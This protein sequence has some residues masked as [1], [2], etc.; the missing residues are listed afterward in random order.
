MAFAAKV[1]IMLSQAESGR[2]G[3]PEKPDR[4][5]SLHYAFWAGYFNWK[6]RKP[7]KGTIPYPA[8][9]AGEIFRKRRL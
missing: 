5:N 7:S 1:Q 6:N 2:I 9:R 4:S 3:S 8:Y